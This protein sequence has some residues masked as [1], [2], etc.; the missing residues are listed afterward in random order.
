MLGWIFEKS[1][2]EI[3]FRFIVHGRYSDVGI[4]W[5]LWCFFGF[6]ASVTLL[7]VSCVTVLRTYSKHISHGLLVVGRYTMRF[8]WPF[9]DHCIIVTGRAIG[10]S[11]LRTAFLHCAKL[12]TERG[13]TRNERAGSGRVCPLLVAGR[14]R[15]SRPR[16]VL[17]AICCQIRATC[18]RHH[19]GFQLRHPPVGRF[20]GGITDA[21]VEI[22]I[23]IGGNLSP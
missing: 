6:H 3:R 22:F 18:L 4:L 15:G 12:Q 19:N 8:C 11:D 13:C 7:D 5:K 14:N 10:M 16:C 17:S 21:D 23:P 20:L 1:V 2:A 9:S